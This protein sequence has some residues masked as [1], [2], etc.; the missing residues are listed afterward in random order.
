MKKLVAFLL[1]CSIVV[2][3]AMADSLA[4]SVSASP[5]SSVS[6]APVTP[7][8]AGDD[9]IVSVKKGDPAPFSGQLFDSDTALRWANYLLQY[10]FRLT[11][12]VAYQKN[13]GD[14]DADLLRQ[15]L[16][17]EEN[18]YT[19]VTADLQKKLD[20]ANARLAAGPAWYDT[21]A[22]GFVMGII[23]TIAVVAVT[24]EALKAV[25]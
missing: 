25:K 24:A 15:K 23:G 12:D 5:S 4:D 11:S 10:K 3:S 14:L 2:Q 13:L 1:L 22:F 21:R 19:T 6:V 9:R 18:R 16:T 17:L 20:A 7:V 8:P